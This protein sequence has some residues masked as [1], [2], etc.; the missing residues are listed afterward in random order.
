MLLFCVLTQQVLI[1]K[2][3]FLRCSFLKREGS[4][5]SY[6]KRHF[7]FQFVPLLFFWCGSQC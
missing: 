2:E 4:K 3:R 1:V 5:F 6:L 7:Y